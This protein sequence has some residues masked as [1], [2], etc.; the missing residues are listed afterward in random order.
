MSM[1][2]EKIGD[3]TV[4]VFFDNGVRMLLIDSK[5][6]AAVVPRTTDTNVVIRS[7]RFHPDDIE[8]LI[9]EWVNHQPVI[10]AFVPQA[11]LQHLWEQEGR[12]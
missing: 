7:Q 6:C 4:E 11:T 5:P 12:L 8:H 3:R 10:S 1:K 9:S 2:W